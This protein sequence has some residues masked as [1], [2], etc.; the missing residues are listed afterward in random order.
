V[1]SRL[2]PYESKWRAQRAHPG[3]RDRL[4]HQDQLD[5]Q[6]LEV[7]GEAPSLWSRIHS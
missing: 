3:R 4:V 5:P 6:A 2:K 1:R 7:V